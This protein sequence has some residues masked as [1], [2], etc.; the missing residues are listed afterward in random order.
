M[1]TTYRIDEEN[2]IFNGFQRKTLA[3]EC[4][5]GVHQRFGADFLPKPK[6]V[7]IIKKTPK[8]HQAQKLHF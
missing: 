4:D 5:R 6:L 1:E 7:K 8:N 3:C 2:L